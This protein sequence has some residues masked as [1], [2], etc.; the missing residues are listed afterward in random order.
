MSC[1]C[2]DRDAAQR[3]EKQIQFESAV[4]LV[5]R[6]EQGY[7][8]VDSQG[9]LTH[10]TLELYQREELAKAATQ[11]E[12]VAKSPSAKQRVAAK[13][14]LADLQASASRL[15]LRKGLNAWADLANRSAELVQHLIAIN[16]AHARVILLST[17][18]GPLI[19]KLETDRDQER[20]QISAWQITR[21]KLEKNIDS[22][23][24]KIT[25]LGTQR[26]DVVTEAQ[27]YREQAFT[28]SGDQRYDLYDQASKS[29]RNAF[30]LGS[31]AQRLR[32]TLD[33]YNS[34]LNVLARRIESSQRFIKSV[35]SQIEDTQLRRKQFQ[36]S[37]AE[38]R[39]QEQETVK[40][41]VALVDQL[42]EDF[43]AKVDVNLDMAL[44]KI[45]LAINHV[46]SAVDD[47]GA[48]SETARLEL[49]GKNV[50]KVHV[51][52]SH[53]LTTGDLGRTLA[54]ISTRAGAGDKPL[55]PQYAESFNNSVQQITARQGKIIADTIAALDQADTLAAEMAGSSD[56]LISE[57]ASNY[58][59]QLNGYR[60]RIEELRLPGAV[61]PVASTK[62][63]AVESETDEPDVMEDS[64]SA[65]TPQGSTSGSAEQAVRGLLVALS[66]HRIGDVW[67]MLPMSYQK[68][69]TDLVHVSAEQGDVEIWKASFETI[70][71]L[72]QVLKDKQEWILQNPMLQQMPDK[73]KLEDALPHIVGL[74]EGLVKSDLTDLEKVKTLDIRSFLT[75]HA[76]KV[77]KHIEALA[78][79]APNGSAAFSSF[80]DSQ[81]T[82][83]SADDASAQLLLTVPGQP[84]L[85]MNLILVEGRW[86]STDLADKWQQNIQLAK[87]QIAAQEDQQTG[88]N[89]QQILAMLSMVG[90]Q[91]DLLN[92][93]ET[94]EQF[95]T[96]MSM[97]TGMIMGKLMEQSQGMGMP[98]GMTIPA[99]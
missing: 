10:D 70:G 77:M 26:D 42:A 17:D 23:N 1:G 96:Q 68:D 89:K 75:G 71:K 11:L 16:H 25:D 62:T 59:D 46:Q 43:Q 45:D 56:P 76:P 69:V 88:E 37:A 24:T 40:K 73:Q 48:D 92:A 30:K 64:S 29:D 7:R 50:T 81:V 95:S 12:S 65:P 52:S 83:V 91:L 49:L 97:I 87:A 85:T 66:E 4:S 27:K 78:A 90:A 15:A 79:L 33:I 98:P 28:K 21:K 51:L 63:D 54:V 61:T 41:L 99:Q 94:P 55:I 6:A 9:K 93:A 31:D 38:A 3:A 35:S 13:L 80:K 67:D 72:V 74:V 20:N 18:D 86:V 84:K 44:E 19:E 34:E 47:A 2:V 60:A 57:H 36:K 32:T 8:P 39:T 58:L 5:A 82:V 14:L 22:L 53:V